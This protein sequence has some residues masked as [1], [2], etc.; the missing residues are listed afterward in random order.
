MKKYLLGF[1]TITLAVGLSVFPLSCGGSSSG[2]GKCQKAIDSGIAADIIAN[3]DIT[4]VTPQQA[5][6]AGLSL[7]AKSSP[8][9]AKALLDTIP[10]T[11][12]LYG[13]AQYGIM[14]TNLQ[15]LTKDIDSLIGM[16]TSLT[17]MTSYETQQAAG[18]DLWSMIGSMIDPIKAKLVAL[19]TEAS[20]V[21]ANG[22]TMST[23]PT[24]FTKVPLVLGTSGGQYYIKVDLKGEAGN[25]EARALKFVANLAIAGIE[26][27]A[28]H[29]LTIDL[30]SA[31]S[32]L[33]GL[34][35]L[36]SGLTGGASDTDVVK[37]LRSLG[38]LLADNPKLL[39][40]STARW[41]T[42][43]GDVPARYVAAIDA[44]RELDAD[45][46]AT[47]KPTAEACKSRVACM[48]SSDAAINTGDQL[49]INAVV[50]VEIKMEVS[51]DMLSTL[52]E[53][54]T[55]LS[56]TFGI[57]LAAT[58]AGITVDM[59]LTNPTILALTP[60]LLAPLGRI[61]P[62]LDVLLLKVKDSINT[63]AAIT[64][65]DINPM[66]EAL[67]P[68]LPLLPVGVFTL[69]VKNLF[70]M[71]L[72]DVTTSF[73][74]DPLTTLPGTGGNCLAIEV[75]SASDCSFPTGC[76]V[77]DAAHFAGITGIDPIAKDGVLPKACAKLSTNKYPL[78]PAKGT[79]Y[80][81]LGDTTLNGGLSIDLTKLPGSYA[82]AAAGST[83][84]YALWK[85]I[86]Y[87]LV[88]YAGKVE[89]SDTSKGM[90]GI[91]DIL[92]NALPAGTIPSFLACP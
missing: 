6:D 85:V 54:K 34:T 23:D 22:Y 25:L 44:L 21:I 73:A 33:A 77:G 28:A 79:I 55:V 15:G 41:S 24:V 40:K 88:D 7:I 50:H 47:A 90:R 76:A 3:C 49:L 68:T 57:T 30:T 80:V 9:E 13:E 39:T 71:P 27:I 31:M 1:L 48:V 46:I 29:D 65:V 11:D 4:K 36:L 62:T 56:S 20:A 92:L 59:D 42:N 89:E 78:I 84:N 75:E 2:G 52:N 61:I 16:V 82:E 63:G 45:L 18:V 17:S 87:Y 10:S 74:C 83:D 64:A 72:R 19:D 14:M 81:A 12:P 67:D 37:A 38:W 5:R 60:T 70:G 58:T 91:V 43:M 8:S 53:F 86:N 69:K 26:T 66:I 32:N 51:A 35:D